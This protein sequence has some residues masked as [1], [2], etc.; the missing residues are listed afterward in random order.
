MVCVFLCLESVVKCKF[1]RLLFTNLI[2]AWISRAQFE[3]AL[4]NSLK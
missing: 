2:T 1:I 3:A 4:A